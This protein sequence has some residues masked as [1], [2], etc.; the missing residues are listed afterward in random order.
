MANDRA[1][2]K[3]PLASFSRYRWEQSQSLIVVWLLLASLLSLQVKAVEMGAPESS[4]VL[5]SDRIDGIHRDLLA[6][7]APIEQGAIVIQLHSTNPVLEVAEHQLLLWPVE[8]GFHGARLTA[9]F[10][11][12]AELQ[13]DLEV[14]GLPAEMTDFVELPEQE[15][16]IE[17]QLEITRE[18]SGYRVVAEELPRFIEVRVKSRLAGQMVT[19]CRGLALFAPGSGAECEGLEQM[20]SV[21][22]LPLPESGETY[23][24]EA[25]KLTGFER[26]QLDGYLSRN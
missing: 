23:F 20:L 8:G 3:Q 5:K 19:L 16:S 18:E 10:Q 9:R 17:A 4:E 2:K 24:I 6:D 11:G 7:I 22:R 21:V 1:M 13:A 12:E 25:A 15:T 26:D 14:A